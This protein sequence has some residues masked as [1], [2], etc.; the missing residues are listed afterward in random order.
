[1][2]LSKLV[3]QDQLKPIMQHYIS[4]QIPNQNR[5]SYFPGSKLAAF[6][7]FQVLEEVL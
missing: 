5:G 1:M 7:H 4:R 3:K 6:K 2:V